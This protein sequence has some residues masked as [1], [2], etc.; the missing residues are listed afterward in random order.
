MS[1]KSYGFGG[2]EIHFKMS[3]MIYVKYIRKEY[4]CNPTYT[5]TPTHRRYLQMNA[6]GQ[7]EMMETYHMNYI[8]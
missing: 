7:K 8:I 5:P 1:C 6:V 4:T 3:D 2:K